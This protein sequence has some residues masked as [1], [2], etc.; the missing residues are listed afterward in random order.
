MN[1]TIQISGDFNPIHVNPYFSYF[2]L[3]LPLSLWATHWTPPML[4][5]PL[6]LLWPMNHTPSQ[7]SLEI[8]TPFMGSLSLRLSKTTPR[9]KQ[10]T[11]VTMLHGHVKTPPLFADINVRHIHLLAGGVFGSHF[12]RWCSPFALLTQFFLEA[13]S[14]SLGLPTDLRLCILIFW[15]LA[16]WSSMVI[17]K[18]ASINYNVY[19]MVQDICIDTKLES[20]S[21]NEEMMIDI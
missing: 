18:L 2:K 5:L 1:R 10:S 17:N 6:M 4:E 7:K 20:A 21:G 11:S 8:S 19:C 14:W 3:W 15:Q 16:S 12:N 13:K 9:K